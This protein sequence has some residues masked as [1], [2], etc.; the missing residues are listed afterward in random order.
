MLYA[1]LNNHSRRFAK[2]VAR[3]HFDNSKRYK[4]QQ[5]KNNQYFDN[6]WPGP[7]YRSVSNCNILQKAAKS[8]KRT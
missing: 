6:D 1:S 5:V 7:E 4:I 3:K 2:K 8:Q